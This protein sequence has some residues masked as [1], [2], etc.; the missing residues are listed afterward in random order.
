MLCRGLCRLW[1]RPRSC[2]RLS[3]VD[4]HCHAFSNILDLRILLI[5]SRCLAIP[6]QTEVQ[7]PFFIFHEGQNDETKWF[8]ADN[9]LFGSIYRQYHPTLDAVAP[10][11]L[12]G[13]FSRSPLQGCCSNSKPYCILSVPFIFFS[14]SRC[15]LYTVEFSSVLKISCHF[16]SYLLLFT[17]SF[18]HGYQWSSSKAT[19]SL[20][21]LRD[22]L[23]QLPYVHWTMEVGVGPSLSHHSMLTNIPQRSCR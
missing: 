13:G 3:G 7:N 5:L 15:I 18:G 8:L 1:G 9:P 17:D 10:P 16:R 19:A 20:E 14:S 23:Q 12:V 22:S 4:V 21:L 6:I 2:R 11:N